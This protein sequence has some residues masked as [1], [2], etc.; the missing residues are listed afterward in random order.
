MGE[1]ANDGA[2]T[3][4][5]HDGCLAGGEGSEYSLALRSDRLPSRSFRARRH[6]SVLERGDESMTV[7]RQPAFFVVATLYERIGQ[8]HSVL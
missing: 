7:D 4:F 8:M 1:G 5:L 3:Y 2:G 6:M